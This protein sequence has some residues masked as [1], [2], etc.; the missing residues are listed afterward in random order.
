MYKKLNSIPYGQVC[1]YEYANG[2]IDL[3]SY[4]TTV[5]TIRNGW[6]VCN[7]LYSR[8]TINHIGKFMREYDL[9]TYY[10]AKHLYLNGLKMNIYTGEVLPL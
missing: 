2:D 4:R 1:V 3:V 10:L 8:T 9:G 5:I 7:G 6:L